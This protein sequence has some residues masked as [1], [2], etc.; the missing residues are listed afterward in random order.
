MIEHS[1]SNALPAQH[2]PVDVLPS[3]P[4]HPVQEYAVDMKMAARLDN[5][6][7]YHA[8]HPDQLPRYEAI[9]EAAR[10]FAATVV[11]LTPPS[12]EQSLALTDIET[13]VMQ[14]NAAIARNE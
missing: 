6:F 2:Q 7:R 4:R 8:P 14:A 3:A 5:T 9:R 10:H 13:A 1:G 11:R 12:R